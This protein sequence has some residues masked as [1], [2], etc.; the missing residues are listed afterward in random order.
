MKPLFT[1]SGW[2]A[3]PHMPRSSKVLTRALKSR[4]GVGSSTPFLTIR[5]TPFFCQMNKRPS[6]AQASPTTLNGERV[7]T[8]SDVK[9]GSV[10][11]WAATGDARGRFGA[12]RASAT[13]SLRARR[14]SDSVHVREPAHT[15]TTLS[16]IMTCYPFVG[17]VIVGTAWE[18]VEWRAS[19]RAAFTVELPAWEPRFEPPVRA[20][21]EER[22]HLQTNATS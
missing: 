10:K 1:K 6:G 11:T 5:T 18:C 17:V 4:N 13:S 7:A 12:R 14:A 21:G 2:K 19:D 20:E 16:W 9:L 8:A 15:S 22:V 3:S